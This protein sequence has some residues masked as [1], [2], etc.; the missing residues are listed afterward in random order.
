[1]TGNLFRSFLSR[2]DEKEGCYYSSDIFS[3]C[4]KRSYLRRLRIDFTNIYRVDANMSHC[5]G[6]V[7]HVA[8]T[9]MPCDDVVRFVGASAAYL[10]ASH[11]RQI[12]RNVSS[13]RENLRRK[14]IQES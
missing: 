12:F 4:G 1:M 14:F 2:R 3:R 8:M 13:S 11:I 10:D 5:T 7:T 6:T 9:I